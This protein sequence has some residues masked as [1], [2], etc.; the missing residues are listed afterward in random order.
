MFSSQ[1]MQTTDAS[2]TV[3]GTWNCNRCPYEGTTD[4]KNKR[5]WQSHN[6][7]VHMKGEEQRKI[8][9]ITKEDRVLVVYQQNGN[10]VAID[11]KIQSVKMTPRDDKMFVKLGERRSE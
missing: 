2:A 10:Q 5:S 7:R 1:D 9:Y 4:Y 6:I 8:G 3:N 11:N